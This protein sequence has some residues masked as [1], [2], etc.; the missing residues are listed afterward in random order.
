MQQSKQ[1]SYTKSS[2]IFKKKKTLR[3]LLKQRKHIFRIKNYYKN[4]NRKELRQKRKILVLIF[5]QKE[6]KE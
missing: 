5:R 3:K 2:K 4:K 1:R 6:N